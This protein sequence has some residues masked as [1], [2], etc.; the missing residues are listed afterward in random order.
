LLSNETNDLTNSEVHKLYLG[1]SIEVYQS[2]NNGMVFTE[3]F[4]YKD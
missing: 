1:E 3:W 2:D 4:T